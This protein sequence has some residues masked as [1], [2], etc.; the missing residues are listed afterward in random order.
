MWL[1]TLSLGQKPH[2]EGFLCGLSPNFTQH[3]FHFFNELSCRKWFREYFKSF[4]RQP[5]LK[6]VIFE[7]TTHHQNA[8]L[9]APIAQILCCLMPRHARNVGSSNQQIRLGVLQPIYRRSQLARRKNQI[10]FSL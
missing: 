1:G 9:M 6:P 10:S 3:F 2:L 8:H 5:R 7:K 4:K